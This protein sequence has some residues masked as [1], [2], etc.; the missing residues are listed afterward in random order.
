[1]LK[2]VSAYIE[3][4]EMLQSGDT[5]VAGVSGGADSV[6]LLL[7]LSAIRKEI[8]FQLFVVHVNHLMR[9]EAGSDAE[10]VRELC[11]K[12]RIPFFLV[13]K[14]VPAIAAECRIST[15][16]A[17]RQVRY[18]AFEAV[19]M[20][21]APE[22]VSENKAKIAVAH[23]LND[24]AETMLFHLFRGSGLNGLSGIRPVS[25]RKSGIT[26]IRPLLSSSRSDIEDFLT[27]IGMNWCIDRTN[28]ED[29]YTRNRIRRH[30]LPFAE[31]EIAGGAVR[32]MA[33]TADILEETRDFV[34]REAQKAYND[35]LIC[36]DNP[37]ATKIK[38][39]AARLA[40]Y[41]SLI[42]K[43]VILSCLEE[44][45]PSKQNMTAAHV[46]A[47]CSLCTEDKNRE[48]MLPCHINARR[49]YEAVVI[50]KKEAGSSPLPKKS[51]Q[52]DIPLPGGEPLE[53]MLSDTESVE[54]SVFPCENSMNIP[55][56]QYTKWFDYDKIE[57]SLSIRTRQTG[58]YFTF[59]PALSKKFLKDYMID[60]KIPRQERDNIWLLAEE[61]HILWAVGYRISTYY[62]IDAG[63]RYILQVQFRGG[64]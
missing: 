46:N 28:E 63:T 35:C 57:K 23:N 14:D 9:E 26:V 56:N 29:T 41:H 60:E 47:V 17:G 1:M 12:C 54:I 16:E 15:E 38:L 55:Q 48:F 24:R 22:A 61:N 62:K 31:K 43:Q 20:R 13:E 7:M 45:T 10:F 51:R 32:N 8:P 59:N 25:T 2:T 49:E 58:D 53:I 21:E 39:H 33:R 6:C 11:K 64:Q 50:E 37:S 36:T 42:Q 19:L 34:Q 27:E 52:I 44:L 30:I 3:R 4:Y 18:E 40:S 5:V